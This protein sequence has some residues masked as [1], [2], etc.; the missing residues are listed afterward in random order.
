MN[1]QSVVDFVINQVYQVIRTMGRRDEGT[2]DPM[3]NA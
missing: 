2:A 1:G 3:S